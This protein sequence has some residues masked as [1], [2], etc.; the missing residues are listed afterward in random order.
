MKEYGKRQRIGLIAGPVLFLAILAMPAP[1][2]MSAE[3]LRVSAVALLMAA[4]WIS[5][6][7]PIPATALL[8]IVLFPVLGVMKTGEVTASYGHP[9][10]FLFVGGFFIAM[11][12]EKCN[13]H[14]RIALHVIR[15]VGTSP[16]R[17][18]FGFM[19]ATAFLSMWI[20]NTATSMMMLPIGLAVVR[21]AR[22]LLAE[23]G[24]AIGASVGDFRFAVALMLGIAYAASIGGVAT[25]IGTPPNAV[26]VGMIDRLYGQQITFASWMLFGVPLS[27]V[28][29][30]LSWLY[31]VRIAYRPEIDELPGGR[32][33]IESQIKRLGPMSPAEMRVLAV[34]AAVALA[35]I[36]RGFVDID[37]LA[38]VTDTTIAIAGA[39]ALFVIPADFRKGEFLL[40]WAHAVRIPWGVIILFGGGLALAGA[41]QASALDQWLGAQLSVLQGAPMIVVLLAVVLVVVFLTE[42]TSNT[43]T[44]SV[45]VPVMAGLAV[46]M[47]VHPFALTVAAGVAASY[48]FMLP[49]A[50]PP[51]AVVF[52]SGYLSVPQMAKAGLW[53]NLLG[54]LLITLFLYLWLPLAW[55]IDLGVLP[56][57]F[58][59]SP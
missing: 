15:R 40:D 59:R 27:V 34:F 42:I 8:P 48:A 10:I 54:A 55:D 53:L 30:V 52:G 11:A 41:F 57:G 58:V 16:A 56:E 25:I 29:L 19:V 36:L 1:A 5:E 4:W 39:L 32:A 51:N 45:F 2:D 38:L 3:A 12:M 24:S 13:L 6:A 31:L 50:T 14:E 47:A 33:L 49:V 21:E 28:M 7:L 26:L 20:S 23:Q 43:A 44:A 17:L 35:W 37:A 18:V 9:L 22:T 46:A